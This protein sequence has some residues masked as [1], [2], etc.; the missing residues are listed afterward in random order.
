MAKKGAES[1]TVVIKGRDQDVFADLGA[2]LRG[3]LIWTGGAAYMQMLGEEVAP[4]RT[5]DKITEEHEPYNLCEHCRRHP[6]WPATTLYFGA[7]RADPSGGPSGQMIDMTDYVVNYASL[8]PVMITCRGSRLSSVS[9]DLRG[10][11]ERQAPE[12]PTLA[13]LRQ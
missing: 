4:G 3:R 5:W 12:R 13:G 2:G 6:R 9:R 7:H 10:L 8:A 11:P 1:A